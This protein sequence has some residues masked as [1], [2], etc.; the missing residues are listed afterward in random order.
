MPLDNQ[1]LVLSFLEQH[2]RQVA[3]G[4][5][6]LPPL[7]AAL[8]V[9]SDG[10]AYVVSVTAIPGGVRAAAKLTPCERDAL[11]ALANATRRITGREI[12]AAMEAVGVRWSEVT[13]WRALSHLVKLGYIDNSKTTPQGYRLLAS[14]L[15]SQPLDE[16]FVS[17]RSVYVSRVIRE[18]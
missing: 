1:T 8:T 5:A 10:A 15:P 18:T 12:L 17:P 3:A 2:V 9:K 7:Q 11:A 14:P 13:L 16:T 6:A 4:L